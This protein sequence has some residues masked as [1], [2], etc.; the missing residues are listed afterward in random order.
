VI[1]LL[2]HNHKSVNKSCYCIGRK[3]ISPQFVHLK[4]SRH[5]CIKYSLFC[6]IAKLKCVYKFWHPVQIRAQTR[7]RICAS[8]IHGWLFLIK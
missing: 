8:F 5:F 7:Y 3:L 4:N 1:F 6:W 2:S